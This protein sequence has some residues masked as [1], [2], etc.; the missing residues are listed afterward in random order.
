MQTLAAA[1]PHVGARLPQDYR[2]LIDFGVGVAT[3]LYIP[4]A[5]HYSHD[6]LSM[7]IFTSSHF[8]SLHK[9]FNEIYNDRHYNVGYGIDNGVE[10]VAMLFWLWRT[11]ET[12]QH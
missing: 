6:C 3:G 9:V 11:I 12:C 10:A 5:Y 4:L 1:T 2:Q 8:V 7:S